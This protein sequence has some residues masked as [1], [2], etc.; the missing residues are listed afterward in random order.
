LEIKSSE[1]NLK[2][3]SWVNFSE[4]WE[5]IEFHLEEKEEFIAFKGKAFKWDKAKFA[6][7]IFDRPFYAERTTEFF[8]KDHI[9]YNRLDSQD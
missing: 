3:L 2:S 4:N 8:G 5:T 6:G 9:V 7:M 1:S